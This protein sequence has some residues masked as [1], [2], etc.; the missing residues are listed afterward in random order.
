MQ[1]PPPF[2]R[3]RLSSL[4]IIAKAL[5]EA[6]RVLDPACGSGNF[7][8]ISLRRMLDLWLEAR[9]FA[10]EQ[11]ISLV[12]SRMVSPSQLYDIEIEFYAHELASVVVWI[13]FLQWK[14]EHG[15]LEDREPVL[16]KL[17]NIEHGDAI[18]RYDSQ[19]QPYEPEWPQVGFIVGNPPFLGG[20]LLRRRLGSQHVD[21]L[22][23]VYAGR[24]KAESDLLIYWFEKARAEVAARPTV[25]VG[26][27]ATQS[28]RGGAN[29]N[30]LERIQ[31]TTPI[32]WAWSDRNWTL[33]GAAVHVSMVGLGARSGEPLALDNKQVPRINP[34]LTSGVNATMAKRLKEND[35]ICFMGTTKV[36]DFDL[37]ASEAKKM[38]SAP[39]NP[40]GRPNSDVVRTWINAKDF[41]GRARGHFII[42]FGTEMSEHDAALYE[43]PFQYLRKH[44]YPKRQ[45]NNRENYRSFWW[46]HGEPRPELRQALTGVKRYIITP[47][48]SK[49][50]LFD[51][52]DASSIPDHAVFALVREDDYFFGVLHSAL[53]E[54]WALHM[55]TQLES[56][57]RYTPD[58]TFDTFPFPWPP[59]QEPSEADDSRV[60]AIADAARELVSLRDKWLNPPDIDPADLKNRTLTNL[61]NLRPAWLENAHQNLDRA[62]FAAYG[63]KY[64]LGSDEILGYLLALNVERAAGHRRVPAPELPLKKAPGVE[65][66]PRKTP[67]VRIASR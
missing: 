40:N 32:Y 13:G 67:S 29:R 42:D 49:H 25:R 62:V 41:T 63:W 4:R 22:F 31:D 39:Q 59:G 16:Q 18:L 30:V 53:H 50:R 8:Y 54:C 7:L 66:L 52:F 14:N 12:V 24:V 23:A 35:R 1:T 51:W 3:F 11:R 27:L 2:S 34:D 5:A 45:G 60:K 47:G 20:K 9:N 15:V 6:V 64:P 36:G 55:G 48:V 43:L 65:R 58:T 17:H 26:L 57:P 46:L 19:G 56:R 21:D 10:A 28:I 38:L 37:E 33:E 61:Y 44:V